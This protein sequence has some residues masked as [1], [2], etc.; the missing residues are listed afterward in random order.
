MQVAYKYINY[1]LLLCFFGTWISQSYAVGTSESVP[2]HAGKCY[3]NVPEH[4]VFMGGEFLA[5]DPEWEDE[6]DAFS[7]HFLFCDL[8]G[9]FS[10]R[11]NSHDVISEGLAV[12]YKSLIKASP[13][14]IMHG[15][16]RV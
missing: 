2:T 7:N 11:G 5:E 10:F 13:A 6:Q 8:L 9:L 14:Y 4:L 15:V 1:I 16:F 3:Q 12:Y